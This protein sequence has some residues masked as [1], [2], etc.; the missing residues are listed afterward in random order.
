MAQFWVSIYRPEG[1]DPALAEDEAVREEISALNRE[2]IAE[3]VR[4]FAGGLMAPEM[5]TAIRRAADGGLD[6]RS[7]PYLASKDHVGG[8]WILDVADQDAAVAWGRK[9]AIACRADVEVWP[10]H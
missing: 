6:L 8:F 4:V 1:Y 2:M 10:F 5:A 7:G 9:A 3:G